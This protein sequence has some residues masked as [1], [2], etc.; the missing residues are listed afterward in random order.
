MAL[1]GALWRRWRASCVGSASS[2]AS[3]GP[4]VAPFLRVVEAIYKKKFNS[5]LFAANY[6]AHDASVRSPLAAPESKLQ[7][8]A[9]FLR[10]V[11]AIYKKKFNSLLF[12]ANYDAHDAK[13]LCQ[14]A[15]GGARERAVLGLRQ[16]CVLGPVVAPFLRVVEAFV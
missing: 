6:D 8:S 7:S 2:S 5:L 13:W 4:V 14:E 15:F 10:V 3:S 11:E 1:S 16:V 12:A 9:P